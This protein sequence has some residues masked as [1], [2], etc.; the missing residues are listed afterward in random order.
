[1][2]PQLDEHNAKFTQSFYSTASELP[3]YR[4]P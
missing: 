3:S 4:S 1:M 2:W